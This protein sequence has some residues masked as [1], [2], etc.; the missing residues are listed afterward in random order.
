MGVWGTLERVP[1]TP[2]NFSRLIFCCPESV[3]V[4]GSGF[5]RFLPPTMYQ[6][7][8]AAVVPKGGLPSMSPANPAFSFV[9]CP[10]PPN[11]PSQRE[12][13]RFLVYFAGGFAP[14][15]PAFNRFRHSQSLPSRYPAGACPV[16][17]LPTLPLAC[18]SAPIPP[19]PFPDGEG[20]ESKFSYARGFAPCIPATEP[21]RHLHD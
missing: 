21:V 2:Q 12:G 13:G 18:F 16:G 15:T 10:H 20:G 19:P 4:P 14:G 7:F 9:S 8:F 3:F 17:R 5:F 1:H 6:W 11:P